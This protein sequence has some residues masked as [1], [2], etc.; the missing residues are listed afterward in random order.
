[1]IKQTAHQRPCFP[2]VVAF[3]KRS[4]FYAAVE[5]V[6]FIRAAKRDLPDVFQRKTGIG[7]KSNRASCGLVQLFPKSSLERSI[8][9]Q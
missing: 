2:C 3:E 4:G 8:V 1:M 5:N 7:G 6:R 9:P